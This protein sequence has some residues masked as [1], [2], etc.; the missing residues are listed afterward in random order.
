MTDLHWHAADAEATEACG[1]RLAQV[2]RAGG[3]VHLTGEL[4]AGKTTFTRGILRHLGHAGAVK[5]PT[6]TLVE[7]YELDGFT[8]YHFDLYRL[9]DPEELELMGYREYFRPDALALVEWPVRG[10]PLLPAPDLLVSLSARLE[11]RDIRLQAGS[12]LG[13]DWLR[14]LAA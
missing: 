9:L 11:G 14:E 2:C 3:I 5:S 13:R 10:E 4:G 12:A 6:Y 8:V 1:A 7:P